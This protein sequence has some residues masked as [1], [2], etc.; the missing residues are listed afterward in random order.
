MGD[1][2]ANAETAKGRREAPEQER[3]EE[4]AEHFDRA[5]VGGP[6]EFEEVK[7]VTIGRSLELAQISVRIPPEDLAALRQQADHA[8][9]G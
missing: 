5:D 2:K 1:T 9:I 3:I 8:G 4:L 7:D 6:A